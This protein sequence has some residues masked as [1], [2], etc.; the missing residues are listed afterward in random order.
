[1]RPC[2]LLAALTGA[3]TALPKPGPTG[4]GLDLSS[5]TVRADWSSKPTNYAPFPMKM[6]LTKPSQT[7]G[8]ANANDSEVVVQG[9]IAA[10]PVS[11][12]TGIA[13]F[14]L[15]AAPFDASMYVFLSLST[16]SLNIFE[17]KRN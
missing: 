9:R 15:P 5:W 11:A 4:P 12:G 3:V 14:Q 2:L 6:K 1:M 10:T 13:D 17:K 16:F 7:S 8:C